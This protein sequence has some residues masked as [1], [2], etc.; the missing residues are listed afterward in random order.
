MQQRL[1]SRLIQCHVISRLTQ[2]VAYQRQTKSPSWTVS[3]DKRSN[4]YRRE[5][6]SRVHSEATA[7]RLMSSGHKTTAHTTMTINQTQTKLLRNEILIVCFAL[8]SSSATH[9]AHVTHKEVAKIIHKVR[10][11]D[12]PFKSDALSLFGTRQFHLNC[13]II[14]KNSWQQFSSDSLMS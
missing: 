9:C 12:A 10:Q 11:S 8:R 5:L 14:W 7:R 4:D 1:I 2:R 3:R 13:D 6:A